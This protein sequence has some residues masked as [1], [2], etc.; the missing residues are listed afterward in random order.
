MI[1]DEMIQWL[2]S[3]AAQMQNESVRKV[4]HEA[5]R[6]MA[7]Q[8]QT[9]E[10]ITMSNSV[11]AQKLTPY[12]ELEKEGRLY[13]FPCKP[14]DTV[15]VI[16]K[17]EDIALVQDIDDDDD[18]D[19]FLGVSVPEVCP[20]DH[21]EICPHTGVSCGDVPENT[22][23]IFKDTVYG[24]EITEGNRI[25]LFLPFVGNIPLDDF[26]VRVFTDKNKA[27]Q[28]LEEIKNGKAD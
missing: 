27:E 28:K 7:Y 16:A 24:I 14:G 18:P 4:L 1:V 10:A 25:V 3:A 15:Y 12:L 6:M 13:A 5:S 11:L 23:A 17:C 20:Y 21:H 9:L 26:G 8:K 22:P 2:Q 19:D